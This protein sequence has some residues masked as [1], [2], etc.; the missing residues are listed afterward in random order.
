M[1][2]FSFPTTGIF[3]EREALLLAV[4]RNLLPLRKHVCLYLTRPMVRPEPVLFPRREDA[5]APDAAATHFYG[6]VLHDEGRFRMWYYACHFGK[7]PDYTGQM[8]QQLVK[9]ESPLFTGPICYAESDDGLTWERPS[10]GQVLFKGSR[11]NNVVDLPHPLIGGATVIKDMADPDP[12]RRYKMVYEF[13]PGYSDPPIAEWGRMPTFA[14]A[15]SAD[16]LH[17]SM[18]DA[19]FP[20]DFGEQASFYRH[21]GQYIINQHTIHDRHRAEGG[22]LTGRRGITRVSYDFE[23]WLDGGFQ[24]SFSLPEPQDYEQRGSNF[25]YDQVHLGVGAA[26]FGTVCVGLYGLWHN[27]KFVGDFDQISCDLGLVVS[28]DGHAYYEPAPGYIWLDRNDSPATPWPGERHNTNL[29]QANGILN[30]GDETRIYHG[31]WLNASNNTGKAGDNIRKYSAE[32]GLAT[33]PRDRWGALGLSPDRQEGYVCS[34]PVRLPVGDADVG[35]SLNADGVAGMRVEVLDERC[36]PI[37]EFAGKQA[38][39]T[40]A[41]DGFDCSVAWSAGGLCQLA[42]RTVRFKVSMTRTGEAQPRLYAMYLRA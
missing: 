8:A 5:N 25:K 37:S 34:A 2:E 17:W 9:Y 38:G 14:T 28:S 16:G 32:V 29:C 22:T 21:N 11:D 30:V 40:S 42:G 19:P 24:E 31:R 7:N 13:Y 27:A 23:D 1:P 3:V 36:A 18:L 26:S 10:L 15:I 39:T 35:L 33:L 12:A 41:R 6:T 20:N 4:D